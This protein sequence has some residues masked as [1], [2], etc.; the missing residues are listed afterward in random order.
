VVSIKA[1]DEVQADI[2]MQR[3]KMVEIAGHVIGREGPASGAWVS[4]K[5]GGDDYGLDRQATTDDKGRFEMKGI[6]PGGYFIFVY[7]RDEGNSVYQPRGQQKLE[8]SG[9]NIDSIIISLGGGTSFQ[10]RVTVEGA[11]STRLD[12]IGIVLSNV[13]DDEQLGGPG[14]IK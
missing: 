2:L 7:Q 6:P 5:L 8:V 13:D 14:R 3:T 11:S 10:G 9:E 1:G 12:G 4:L